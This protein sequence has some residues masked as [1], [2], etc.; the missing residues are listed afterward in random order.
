MKYIMEVSSLFAKLRE[1]FKTEDE[2]AVSDSY[3][4]IIKHSKKEGT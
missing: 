4:Y 1:T 2:N 3:N